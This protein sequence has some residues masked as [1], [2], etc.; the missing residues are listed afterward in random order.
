MKNLVLGYARGRNKWFGFS[1]ALVDAGQTVD[2]AIDDFNNIRGQY[3][4]IWCMAESLLPIQA[5]LEKKWGLKNVSEKAAKILT[6][7]KKFDDFCISIG[8]DFLIPYSVIPTKLSDLDYFEDR[9]FVIKPVIGSGGKQNYKTSVAYMSYQNTEN[10]M[11]SVPCDLLFYV[12]QKGYKDKNFNNQNN[13]YMAQEYLAHSKVYAPYYYVNE[14]GQVKHICTI[15]G[16]K[17]YQKIDEYRFESKPTDFM[18]V[19]DDEIPQEVLRYRE[20]FYQTIVD[21]LQVKNMFFAGPDFYYGLGREIKIIDCNPRIGQG[22]QILNEVHNGE[23]LPKIILNQEF[24]IEKKFWWV[25]AKIKPGKIKEVKDMS[26]FRKY[27]TTTNPVLQPGM[28]FPKLSWGAQE[29]VAKI[30]LKIPGKNKS[31]MLETYRTLSKQLQDCIVY[32]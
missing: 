5:R 27:F 32:V 26:K 19:D 20:H 10:F 16:N 6:N 30:A 11:K 23:L 12:N 9:A 3:D 22:L 31:D 8:L 1:K 24:E 7:K 25:I 17:K 2:L 21:E 15:E 28:V 18:M 13:Y 14:H 4:R 29:N